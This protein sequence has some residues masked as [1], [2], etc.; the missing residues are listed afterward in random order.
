MDTSG[1]LSPT[2]KKRMQQVV[3]TLL[4]YGQVVDPNILTAISALASQ[5][6]TTTEETNTKLLQ[7]IN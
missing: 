4:Y 2:G 7:L 1:A 5:Q 3:G 6:S